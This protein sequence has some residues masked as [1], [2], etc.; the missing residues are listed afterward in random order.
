MHWIH[1]T[2]ES[3]L[4]DI[5]TKSQEKSQ[6]IFKFSSRC[7]LSQVIY[8]R[9]Q[10]KCCPGSADFYFLDLLAYRNVSR[11]ITDKFQVEHE[12]PQVLV[13]RDGQCIYAESHSEIDPEEIMHI[14]E[15][16]D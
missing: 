10:S 1:L 7:Y 16:A 9:L 12:S 11:V 14:A 15:F 13:I 8:N 3:Q 4:Q 6:V 2:D 5:F